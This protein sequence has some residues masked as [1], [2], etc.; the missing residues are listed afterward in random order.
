MATTPEWV[1]HA[2]FY[3]IFPDRFARVPQPGD[4]HLNLQ[5]WHSPPTRRGFKGG[6]LYGV[7]EKLDYLE[8][9]GITAIYFNPIFASP[10][11]HRYHTY[12]YY[13]VDPLLGGNQAFRSLLDEAHQRGMRIVLDGV[14]NHA[15]RGFWQFN[16]TLE[17]K[18]AS[19]YVDWFHFDED[20]LSGKTPWGVYRDVTRNEEIQKGE[21]SLKAYGYQAWWDLPALPK[22]NTNA[23]A[24]REFI[25]DVAEYWIRFGIDGWRLDVPEEIDDISFWQ[26]FRRRVKS[27]NPEAYLVGE[28]WQEARR[29]LEGDQF[30]A[31]MNYPLTIACLGFFANSRINREENN[32]VGDYQT[33]IQFLNGFEFSQTIAKIFG[34]YSPEINQ[35]QLNLLESHDTP[36]FIT[37]V[38]GDQNSLK[39]AAL[40]MF[41]IPGAPT[42]YYGSEIGLDGKKDPDCRKAFPWEEES[43]DKDLFQYFQACIKLRKTHPSLRTGAYRVLRADQFSYVFERALPGENLVVAF[44]TGDEPT[45]LSLP[46]NSGQLVFGEGALSDGD[47]DFNISI[48]PRQGVVLKRG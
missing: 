36:R 15:S 20:R 43:W 27:I 37:Y 32:P 2:I 34:W 25:F 18:A 24:V 9:L 33:R 14:F 21:G 7:I 5:D 26:E 17:N 48:G 12:D 35:V 3:Q 4:E 31:V 8:E 44:N 42:I 30:D 29:W 38:E 41:T 22:F 46:G 6:N 40:F 11:N 23:P 28:I 45:S 10:A 19:P 13:N 47:D 1:K 16:H 39:L